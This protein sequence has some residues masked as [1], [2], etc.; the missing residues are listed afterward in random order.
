MLSVFEEMNLYVYNSVR[1]WILDCVI[2]CL[3]PM[4]EEGSEY[5]IFRHCLALATA[6][7]CR[8]YLRIRG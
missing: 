1:G 4:I 2:W 5:G 3:A 8:A 6:K 7:T